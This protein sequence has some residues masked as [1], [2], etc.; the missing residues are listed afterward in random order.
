M[1]AEAIDDISPAVRA[2]AACNDLQGSLTG[3]FFSEELQDIAAAKA[4]CATCPVILDCLEGAIDRHEPWGVW[5]GQMFLNGKILATKR[6]RGRPPKTP[7]PEDQLPDIPVPVHLQPCFAELGYKK[8][9]FPASEEQGDREL[10]LPMYPEMTEAQV[11]EV[12]GAL[13]RILA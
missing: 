5:G 7:R 11:E 1:L 2:N 3:V 4:I 9:D 12:A 13:K 6:R 10:S 8:G